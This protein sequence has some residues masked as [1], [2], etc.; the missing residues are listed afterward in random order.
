LRLADGDAGDRAANAIV[1]ASEQQFPDAGWEVR[2]RANA[3]PALGRN[4]ERFTQY[5]TLVGLT[6]LLVGGVGVA[7]AVKH[8]LDRKRDV[9]ATFKALGATGGIIFATYLAQVLMLALLGTAIGLA[10]GAALPFA[11][12]AAFGPAIAIPLAPAIHPGEL[13]LAAA[14]GLLTATAF[15]LWP[16]GRAHDVPVSA[17][18]RDEV[19]PAERRP[20][21]RSG[22]G[23]A[24]YMDVLLM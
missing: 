12:A 15:A 21:L 10:I 7:N 14:Y 22:A 19:A 16:L 17:L 9:I 1:T 4:I 13:A 6:A 18:F 11:I 5:L 24:D 20:R 2:T 23:D 8:Y 3:S